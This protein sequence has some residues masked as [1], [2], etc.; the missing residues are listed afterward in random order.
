MPSGCGL[1]PKPLFPSPPWSPSW[2]SSPA[3]SWSWSSSTCG[4]PHQFLT[5][6]LHR[7]PSAK[8][9]QPPFSGCCQTWYCGCHRHL[10]GD[11]LITKMMMVMMMMMSMMMIPPADRPRVPPGIGRCS[12]KAPKGGGL[13][14]SVC[15]I[16]NFPRGRL[17]MFLIMIMRRKGVRR[18]SSMNN[19]LIITMRMLRVNIMSC[20]WFPPCALPDVLWPAVGPADPL[21]PLIEDHHNGFLQN[22][23]FLDYLL[24]VIFLF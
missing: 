4:S 5:P 20:W 15:W 9:L 16:L 3:S 11:D 23:Y 8:P 6:V 19:Q 21:A 18:D 17:L 2:S 7:L 1:E 14:R 13:Y 24:C 10:D 12:F 22:V